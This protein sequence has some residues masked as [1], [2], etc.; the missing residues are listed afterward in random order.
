MI[1]IWSICLT[2]TR[3]KENDLKNKHFLASKLIIFLNFSVE[4][5]EKFEM[6][7]HILTR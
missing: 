2:M 6:L 5:K 3:N 7:S 1:F 4:E